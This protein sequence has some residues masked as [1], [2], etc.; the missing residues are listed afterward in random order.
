MLDKHIMVSTKVQNFAILCCMAMILFLSSVSLYQIESETSNKSITVTEYDNPFIQ[1]NIGIAVVSIVLL[2]YSAKQNYGTPLF[3][4]DLFLIGAQ[5]ILILMF[6]WI[7]TLSKSIVLNYRVTCSIVAL[8]AVTFCCMIF[9]FGKGSRR[10]F[11]IAPISS[12]RSSRTQFRDVHES[13][14]SLNSLYL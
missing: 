1:I 4:L 13:D 11:R 2:T 14:S 12:E 5:V 7:S 10:D 8:C 9:K 3:T 6:Y